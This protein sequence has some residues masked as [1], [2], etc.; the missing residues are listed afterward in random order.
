MPLGQMPV[1]EIDGKKYNQSK[2]VM[3]CLA[4]KFGLYGSSD[5]EAWEIDATADAIDDLRIRKMQFYFILCIINRL[6]LDDS[7]YYILFYFNIIIMYTF[8]IYY[9]LTTLLHRL[10][11]L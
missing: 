1:L 2:A 5:E 11:A 3:R 6:S 7:I 4:K 10:I 8:F 9:I